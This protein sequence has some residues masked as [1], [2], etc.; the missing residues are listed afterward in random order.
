MKKISVISAILLVGWPALYGY[1]PSQ[2]EHDLSLQGTSGAVLSINSYS[3]AG[4]SVV[5]LNDEPVY[6]LMPRPA[7]IRFSG[8]PLKEGQNVVTIKPA[9]GGKAFD[10]KD[11]NLVLLKGETPQ[12]VAVQQTGSEGDYA[13]TGR[14]LMEGEVKYS[15]PFESVESGDA[16]WAERATLS[17]AEGVG[18][19]NPK[20]EPKLL[21]GQKRRYPFFEKDFKVEAKLPQSDEIRVIKGKNLCLVYRVGPD[22]KPVDLLSGKLNEMAFSINTMLWCHSSQH[23]LCRSDKSW[24]KFDKGIGVAK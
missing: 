9:F 7:F 11:L 16:K 17:Y 12:S 24:L 2:V 23:V 20:F 18:T 1:E 15:F 22:G 6:L 10:L 14:F 5:W 19:Q 13:C 8:Y 4:F 3:R 21:E